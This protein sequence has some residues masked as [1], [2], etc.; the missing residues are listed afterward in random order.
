MAQQ[1]Q[2]VRLGDLREE[3]IREETALAQLREE[4]RELRKE[5]KGNVSELLQQIKTYEKKYH[6]LQVERAQVLREKRAQVAALR[7]EVEQLER[8]ALL[9]PT[10][11][12]LPIVDEEGQMIAL[13]E[14]MFKRSRLNST[15]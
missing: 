12:D 11:D 5:R 6:R 14:D 4:V 8:Q 15:S 10:P 7:Q 13:L 3:V 1:E 2:R 9:R